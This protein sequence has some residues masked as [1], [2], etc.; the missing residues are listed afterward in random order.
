MAQAGSAT[1]TAI[2]RRV[3]EPFGFHDARGRPL[4]ATCMKVLDARNAT[5]RIALPARRHSRQPC[6]LG[7]PVLSPTGLPGRDDQVQALQLV[8]VTDGAQRRTWNELMAR[9]HPRVVLR[10]GG[11][12]SCAI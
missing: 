12:R 8:E 1:R 5:G 11:G 4:I 3:C 2:G 9:E 7:C 10:P 6:R